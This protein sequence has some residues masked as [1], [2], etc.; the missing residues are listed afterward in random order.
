M[1]L[2]GVETGEGWYPVE[3]VREE[4]EDEGENVNAFCGWGLD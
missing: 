1:T 2:D 3:L 4:S